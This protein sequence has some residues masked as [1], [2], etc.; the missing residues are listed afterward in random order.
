VDKRLYLDVN[1]LSTRT[2]WAH[3]VAAFL[4]RPSA[5]A[6]LAV[7]LVLA[8]VRARTGDL[9]GSD[10]DQMA[11]LLWTVIASGLALA[12][13]LPIVH[14]VGRARPF[15]AMPQATVL[16]SKPTGFGF[17]NEHAVLAGAVAA[18]LW[19]CRAWLIAAI[20]TLTALLIA[21]AVVYT[22]VAYP[23][24]ALAGLLLGALV[25]LVLYPFAI[26]LLRL[27]LHAVAQ[28]PLKVV[29]GGGHHG[30]TVGSGPAAHPEP[31]GESGAVRIL[32]S[33]EVTTVRILPREETDA[34]A[35]ASPPAH[36]TG[37]STAGN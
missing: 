10:L 37:S 9:G 26:V 8:F 35:A 6:I 17:P 1:R 31:V 36:E 2:A 28:S 13:S 24:D 5:L 22:G 29:V 14:L 16:I 4:A 25:T 30:R 27:L 33:K 23:G 12:V 21:F 34:G 18:G 32:S 3:G 11:A 20:A 19:L 15:V 7:L